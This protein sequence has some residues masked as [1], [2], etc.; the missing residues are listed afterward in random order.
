M[1]KE[2][3]SFDI[4]DPKEFLLKFKDKEKNSDFYFNI[5]EYKI[6]KELLL[7]LDW[8]PA[9]KQTVQNSKAWINAK[10]LD[11]YFNNWIG[12][13]KGYENVKSTYDDP[14]I[15]TFAKE[16]YTEFEIVDDDSDVNPFGTKLIL[17]LDEH[18]ENIENE[19]EKYQTESNK[20]EI[21]EIKNDVVELRQN[22]TKKSKKWV[23]KNLTMTWAKITKQGPKLMKEFLS[24]AKKYV[25][26]EGAKFLIDNG[27]DLIK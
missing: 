1:K 11:G 13:L 15:E 19:I 26:K 8:K 16:Y 18:L 9:N 23:V 21:E 7:L 25:I 14:I 20:K 3:N 27:I 17:L 5:E 24:E 2:T 12:L 22:L 4:Q 10:H 6:E